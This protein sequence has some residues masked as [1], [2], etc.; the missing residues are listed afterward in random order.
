MIIKRLW[1]SLVIEAFEGSPVESWYVLT[2]PCDFP[3]LMRSRWNKELTL[4]NIL[5]QDTARVFPSHN[6]NWICHKVGSSNAKFMNFL[7]KVIPFCRNNPLSK[8]IKKSATWCPSVPMCHYQTCS[9]S[10]RK[11]DLPSVVTIQFP[12]WREWKRSQSSS[13][14]WNHHT[15]CPLPS[16]AEPGCTDPVLMPWTMQAKEDSHLDTEGRRSVGNFWD[17][18]GILIFKGIK[19]E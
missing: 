4:V 3:L 18:L 1:P 11:T 8:S 14:H 15:L 10:I 5:Q 16:T 17:L 9:Q 13:P 6:A 19:V 7:W 12:T 2:P